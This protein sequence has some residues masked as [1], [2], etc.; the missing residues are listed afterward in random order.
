[1]STAVTSPTRGHLLS[2]TR[3]ALHRMLQRLDESDRH[4]LQPVVAAWDSRLWA[5]SELSP[6][7]RPDSG[8]ADAIVEELAE[9]E[10]LDRSVLGDWLDVLPRNVMALLDVRSTVL[11][12]LELLSTPTNAS[13]NATVPHTAREWPSNPGSNGYALAA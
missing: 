3:S 9:I 12:S 13:R 5:A 7:L 10:Q 11:A 4:R 6:D 1:M 2:S 8:T